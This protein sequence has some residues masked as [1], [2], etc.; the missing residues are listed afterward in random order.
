ME[1]DRFNT[2]QEG[3]DKE[4]VAAVCVCLTNVSSDGDSTRSKEIGKGNRAPLANF[5]KRLTDISYPLM[6][7]IN[8]KEFTNFKI[9]R[10]SEKFKYRT[11]PVT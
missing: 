6:F 3:N 10:A 4:S 2:R 1:K 8:C 7:S 9:R 5:Q 11:S